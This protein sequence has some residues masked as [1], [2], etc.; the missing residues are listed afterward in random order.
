[1]AS[2]PFDKIPRT[3]SARQPMSD[4]SVRCW[5]NAIDPEARDSD[6]EHADFDSPSVTLSDRRDDMIR[7]WEDPSVR[8][9]LIRQHVVLP[10]YASL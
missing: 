1:M 10:E 9:A 2:T 7:L 6:T 8:M 5:A 3:P 4:I